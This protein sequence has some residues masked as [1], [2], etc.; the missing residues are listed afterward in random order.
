MAW[1]E[2]NHLPNGPKRIHRITLALGF[3][4]TVSWWAPNQFGRMRWEG[5]PQACNEEV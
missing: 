2:K 5:C 3:V 4:K 1:P